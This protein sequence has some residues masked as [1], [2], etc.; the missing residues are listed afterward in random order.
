MSKL[1]IT[2]VSRS[3]VYLNKEKLDLEG[4]DEKLREISAEEEDDVRTVV[5]EGDREMPYDLLV[6]VLD[7]LRQNGY[8]GIN[9]RTREL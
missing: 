1:V 3:E 4:L 9:L 8:R 7:I 6:S 5:L 2:V